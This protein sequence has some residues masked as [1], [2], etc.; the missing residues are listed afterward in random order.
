MN[1]ATP[2]VL[3][4]EYLISLHAVTKVIVQDRDEVSVEL[5]GLKELLVLGRHG[6]LPDVCACVVGIQH[7]KIDW[8]E[9]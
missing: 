6:C 3:D 8:L 7:V 1:L 4:S 2:R 9:A 5:E